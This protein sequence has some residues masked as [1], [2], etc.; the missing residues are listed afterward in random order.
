[1]T[2]AELSYKT[3]RVFYHLSLLSLCVAY[4]VSL[5]QWVFFNLRVNL[6]G[7]IY[8]VHGFKK[9]FFINKYLYSCIAC[10]ILAVNLSMGLA[11]TLDPNHVISNEVAS[12]YTVV[13]LSLF[14]VCFLVAGSILIH[15]LR[16]FFK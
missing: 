15:N 8:S 12:L 7:G 16:T 3:I 10:I 14:L 2:G 1:M 13:Q 5:Y 9:R 4:T 11:E 6:Y